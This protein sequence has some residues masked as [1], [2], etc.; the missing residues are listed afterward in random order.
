MKSKQLNIV[1]PKREK[2]VSR[3]RGKKL[4]REMIATLEARFG[5]RK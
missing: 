3:R 2:W 5:K 4:F 1:W